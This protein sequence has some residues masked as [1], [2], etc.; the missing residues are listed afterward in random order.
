MEEGTMAKHVREVSDVLAVSRG[1]T[2]VS[3]ETMAFEL[4]VARKTVQNWESGKSEPTLSQAIKWF[5]VL[6]V[7]P[8]PYLYQ[9]IYPEMKGISG[10]DEEA[11]IR[12]ALCKLTE[13]LPEEMVRQMLYLFYGDHGSSPRAI[14]QMITAHLQTPMND[15]VSHGIVIVKDYEMAKKKGQLTDKTHIQPNVE[16]LHKAI[17]EGE[18]AF[19][20]GNEAYTIGVEEEEPNKKAQI[21]K[22]VRKIEHCF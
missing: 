15:R 18:A 16:M 2:K 14:M 12:E 20:N 10:A 11:R 6:G 19:L 3:Q 4:E 13:A 7:S 9:Y 21:D 22:T 1:R 5:Q 17:D 8:L